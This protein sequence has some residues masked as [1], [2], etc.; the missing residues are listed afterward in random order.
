MARS[1]RSPLGRRLFALLA[2]LLILPVLL[3]LCALLLPPQYEET[4]LGEMKDK[5]ERL[6]TT[7]GKRIVVVGGSS[8]PFSLDSALLQQALPGYQVVDFGMYA[9]LGTVV[10]L[11]WALAEV[12]EGDI[13]VL[14]P[15][16]AAQALSCHVGGESVWQAC[17]G[18]FGNLLLLSGERWEAVVAA[19][20]SFAGKKLRY[21]LL[22][23]LEPEGI[24]RHDAFNAYGD[25]DDP[26]RTRNVMTGGYQAQPAISFDTA[27]PDDR[28]L[29][30]LNRFAAEVRAR[31]A[32][33]VYHFSPMNQAALVPGTTEAAVDAYY[34]FLAERLDMPLL[35]NPHDCLLESG[36]FY[37][38]DFHLNDSGARLFTRLLAGDLKVYLGDTAPLT[39]S[40]P[41]MPALRAEGYAG[42]DSCEDCFTYRRVEE[43]WE[44]D[45]LTEAGRQADELIV[46]TRH[47]GLPVVGMAPELFH[48]QTRLRSVTVQPN[49]RMLWDGLFRG[50]TGLRTLRLTGTDPAATVPGDGLM[51]G[52]SFA[53][54]VPGEAL[55]AYRRSYFWQQYEPW[56]TAEAE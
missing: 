14:A 22:G 20:P 30:A 55:D 4:F 36:W 26:S 31:G 39:L 38:S 9:D 42:D 50:C 48:D 6:R 12:H 32:E 8:V 53:I 40:V 46:P 43:G 33:A 56:L 2:A 3:G 37:D 1:D 16:Q 11:D 21:A 7:P 52:A 25:I 17:D 29:E 34:D 15:E 51:N 54:L 10:M 24:Y 23:R 13:F 49:I 27:L 47:E 19:F 44:L 45:G 35:G 5:L 41:E 28:F 18:A